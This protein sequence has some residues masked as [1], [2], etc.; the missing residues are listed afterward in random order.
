MLKSILAAFHLT[1]DDLKENRAGKLTTDQKLKLVKKLV[2]SVILGGI[3]AFISLNFIFSLRVGRASI[4]PVAF[5]TLL[6][7]ALGLERTFRAVRIASDL[8]RSDT[9]QIEDRILLQ[10]LSRRSA[11]LRVGNMKFRISSEQL[12]ALRNGERYTVYYTPRSKMLTSVEPALV[13]EGKDQNADDLSYELPP[14][15]EKEKRT[16][17]LGEDGELIPDQDSQ[18]IQKSKG[19]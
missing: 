13:I 4:A 2:E 1:E 9:T 16:F 10:P 11:R 6:L 3:L 18:K 17:R 5:V 7:I 15:T 19:F 8:A 12:L 14:Q